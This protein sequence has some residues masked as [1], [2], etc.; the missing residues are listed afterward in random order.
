MS[1]Y[2]IRRIEAESGHRP[3]EPT[4]KSWPSK[5]VT[6]SNGCAGATLRPATIETHDIRHVFLMTGAVP[7]TQW[8]DGCVAL[9]ARFIKTGPDLSPEDL[10]AAHWPLARAPHLLETSLPG[11]FAVG[12]VRG[13]NSSAWRRRW[14]RGRS[15]SPSCIRRCTNRRKTTMAEATCAHIEAITTVKRREAPG[16]RRVRE[17]RRT[18]GP[19]ADL[20]GVRHDACCDDSPNRHA[21]KHAQASKHPVIASAEPGERWLYCYPDDESEY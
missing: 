4:P 10:S 7:G 15:R 12:D 14:A 5:G 2:L 1:R 18:L 3:A 6:I 20:P 8:L 11:V 13:G 16:V 21:T 9:D 17:D 19:P